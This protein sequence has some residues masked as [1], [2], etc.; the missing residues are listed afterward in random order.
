[1][2]RK[3]LIIFTLLIAFTGF[4]QVFTIDGIQYEVMIGTRNSLRITD[5]TNTGNVVIPERVE[6]GG[7]MYSVT[8]IG[9]GAFASSELTSII[10]PNSVTNI[11]DAVFHDNQ[12]TSV[13][14]PNNVISIGNHAFKENELTSI[15][16]PSSVTNIGDNAFENNPL[17]SVIALGET[18][19]ITTG[20]SSGGLGYNVFPDRN[21]IDLI[22]PEDTVS[23]YITAKWTNFKSIT[24]GFPLVFII[25]NI[26]YQVISGSDNKVI[27]IDN[28][29]TGDVIIPEQVEYGGIMYSVTSIGHGTFASSELTSITIPNSVTNIGILAFKNNKLTS[30]TI[31]NSISTIN[32]STFENNQLVSVVLPYSISHINQKAFANNPLMSVTAQGETPAITTGSSSGG[33]GDNVFT[34]RSNID[35]I[36]P[37]GTRSTYIAA[38]WTGF[39][40]ITENST[41]S[42]SDIDLKNSVHVFTQQNRL[43]ISHPNTIQFNSYS[44]YNISGVTAL[45]GKEIDVPTIGL[46]KGLYIIALEFNSGLVFKKFIKE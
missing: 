42:I 46:A 10:I 29:N 9:H 20:S 43:K 17:I 14:I 5:N 39:K 24:E 38:E 6:Y 44:I 33:L 31:P 25:D 3:L 35:L 34:D 32:R 28:T 15:T 8:S 1:M 36:I 21:N 16:I 4:S 26:K 40:S 18:P 30:L 19:A 2:K 41:L 27:I 45:Q 7:I 22:I 23:E 13:T 12:L 11:G 37:D